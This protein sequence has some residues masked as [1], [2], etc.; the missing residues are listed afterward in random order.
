M[1]R[2]GPPITGSH[3][4]KHTLT[5]TSPMLHHYLRPP[6]ALYLVF[7]VEWSGVERSPCHSTEVYSKRSYPPSSLPLNGAINHG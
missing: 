1:N 2:G 6:S 5:H 7:V 3:L 4:L